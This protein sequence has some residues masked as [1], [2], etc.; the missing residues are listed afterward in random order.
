M[1]Y[2]WYQNSSEVGLGEKIEC[3]TV[4]R[5]CISWSAKNVGNAQIRSF[6]MNIK[7]KSIAKGGEQPTTLN[8]REQYFDS[9]NAAW[10]KGDRTR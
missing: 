10:T 4:V 6:T 7:F 2:N 5:P 9:H 1:T 8:E 3:V